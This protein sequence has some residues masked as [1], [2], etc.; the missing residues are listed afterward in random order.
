MWGI[1]LN[2]GLRAP[3]GTS[4]DDVTDLIEILVDTLDE[5]G[6]EPDV[7]THLRGDR[8]VLRLEVVVPGDLDPLDAQARGVNAIR[9]ALKVGGIDVGLLKG[10][11]IDTTVR[12]LSPV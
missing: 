10:P 3:A 11:D 7:G 8:I 12:E 4:D 2:L 1:A 9:D 6:F 5:A